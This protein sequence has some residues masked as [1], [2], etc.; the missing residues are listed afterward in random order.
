MP[1]YDG[2]LDLNISSDAERGN[3][4]EKLVGIN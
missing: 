4:R 2:A 1:E 3:R